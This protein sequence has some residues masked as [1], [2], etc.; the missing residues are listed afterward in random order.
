MLALAFVTQRS[1]GKKHAVR[2]LILAIARLCLVGEASPA[3]GLIEGAS[4][5]SSSL[6]RCHQ[7]CRD[8]VVGCQRI[9]YSSNESRCAISVG[10]H[11]C[12]DD[13]T[14]ESSDS[15][16]VYGRGIQSGTS[17]CATCSAGSASHAHV[18]DLR[19]LWGLTL[20]GT[21]AGLLEVTSG[22]VATYSSGITGQFI[23]YHARADPRYPGAFYL[24]HSS[25]AAAGHGDDWEYAWLED[26][27]D[28][29]E[30]QLT[31]RRFCGKG[32]VAC[33]Q[34]T[35]PEGSPHFWQ[36]LIGKLKTG[37]DIGCPALDATVQNI[38]TFS[39]GPCCLAVEGV[40]GRLDDDNTASFTIGGITW[41]DAALVEAKWNAAITL[42]ALQA[43][44]GARLVVHSQD[45]ELCNDVGSG[46]F[47]NV[48]TVVI[49]KRG[50]CEFAQKATKGQQAGA[51]AVI[52]ANT[53]GS[54]LPQK[55][56]RTTFPTDPS[57]PTWMVNST[58][59]P[60]LIANVWGTDGL[61]VALGRQSSA[62]AT[63][64]MEMCCQDSCVARVVKAAGAGLKVPEIVGTCA[65]VDCSAYVPPGSVGTPLPHAGNACSTCGTG[66]ASVVEGL[67][68]CAPCGDGDTADAGKCTACPAGRAGTKGQCAV[69]PQGKTAATSR[70]QCLTATAARPAP[71]PAP[72]PQPTPTAAP[73]PKPKYSFSDT[74]DATEVEVESSFP[75]GP[76]VGAV[77][78]L[79]GICGL[80]FMGNKFYQHHGDSFEGAGGGMAGIAAVFG[81]PQGG[82]GSE[83][84]DKAEKGEGEEGKSKGGGGGESSDK[85]E[86]P[87]L[88]KKEQKNSE[89]P[90]KKE[91]ESA[92][93]GGGESSSK[94]PSGGG[95]GGAP[96]S[97]TL[98][99]VRINFT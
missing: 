83:K 65:R 34:K 1:L 12:E 91:K 23:L 22:G 92:D 79:L 84:E 68:N 10:L 49:A 99:G 26:N 72:T 52:I 56:L 35:S 39:K 62:S 27:A 37:A 3:C 11:D 4:L 55:L 71:T 87:A 41:A 21:D 59:G 97:M 73:T 74:N 67:A 48:P 16:C 66:L 42:S 17:T 18:G 25:G 2:W 7:R 29:G 40:T 86:K 32:P 47:A 69:C 33:P 58:V 98:G 63:D 75:W 80:L 61:L 64:L 19:G 54:S 8:S 88:E 85:K 20:N 70:T 9:A 50:T 51:I 24:P 36:T 57:I 44:Q 76:I 31:V 95:G 94:K 93:S 45:Q 43:L 14:L 13:W 81:A 90:E 96:K 78:C 46:V 53:P 30:V 28:T 60:D 38:G 77:V 5:L 89:K 82:A 15:S 6:A